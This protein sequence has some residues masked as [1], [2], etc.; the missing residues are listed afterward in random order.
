M[1]TMRQDR[2]IVIAKDL[3]V[4]VIVTFL[5]LLAMYIKTKIDS[6]TIP[7]TYKEYRDNENGNN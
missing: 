1:T 5:V 4:V 6:N 3:L 2:W 7:E